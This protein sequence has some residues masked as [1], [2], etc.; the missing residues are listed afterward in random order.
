MSFLHFYNFSRLR[1]LLALILVLPLVA[2]SGGDGGLSNSSSS[3]NSA[4]LSWVAPSAREDNSVLVLSDIAGFRVYY[5]VSSGD[6]SNMVDI[7][8]H[9]ATQAV[10]AGLP[11]GTYYIAVTVVDVDGR[12]SLYSAEVVITV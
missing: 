4:K 10:L 8:D 3:P 5:G 9:T 7:N 12:E 11:S 2:C 1:Y 6:Y